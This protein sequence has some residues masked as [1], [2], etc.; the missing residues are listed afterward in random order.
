MKNCRRRLIKCLLV[1]VLSLSMAVPAAAATKEEV[2][3]K[4]NNLRNQQSELESQLASLKK[5]K[6]DTESYIKEL[7]DKI[8]GYVKNLEEV[9]AEL[10]KTEAE[11]TV[12]QENLEEAK[13]NEGIQY[14]ALKARI[15]AIYE[16]GSDDYL[17]VLLG[18]G[19]LKTLLNDSEYVSRINEYDH[20]LLMKLQQIR[21]QIAEYEESLEEKEELQTAQKEQY[22]LEKESLEKIVADKE[23]ELVSING[24]ITDV[25]NS[26]SE[27]Q[28]AIDANNQ[29]LAEIIEAERRAAE[30]A[31]RKAA[32]EAAARKAAEEAAARKAA[33]EAAARKAA[34]EA[35]AQAEAAVEE[36]TY[37]SSADEDSS[38]YEDSSYD[39]Y[40][41]DDSS[42]DYDDY[43]YEEETS[44]SSSGGFIWPCSATSI[45]SSFGYRDAPT[46]GATTYH[47]GI[48]IGASYGDSAWAAAGGTVET[49]SYSSAM[50]N[51]VVIDHGN[52]V[53]TCYEHLSAIYVSAGQSVSQ[54]ETIGAVGSTGISTGAHLH[55]GVIVGGTYVNPFSYVS[56]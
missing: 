56:P 46:A 32:E 35:A 33:E 34:E 11:I 21:D 30:E 15:K 45:N 42:Y 9:S 39:D 2:Q 48:D 22:E 5:N 49:A 51:Y 6:S 4:I 3:N 50:G 26:I 31:A 41:Y 14:G 36:D 40:S 25:N 7:D 17:Q 52:G 54:G 38:S 27:N 55:F 16:S 19:D 8:S 47:Q 23:D 20:D 1:A 28:E 29:L 44:S 13:V 18:S 43:S 10:I 24:N 37:D 53:S 12:T